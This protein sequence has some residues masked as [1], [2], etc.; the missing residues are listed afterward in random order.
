MS[1]HCRALFSLTLCLFAFGM[2]AQDY[3]NWVRQAPRLLDS[4]FYSSEAR[5]VVD[6][7]LASQLPTGAWPKNV[8]FFQEREQNPGDVMLGTIDNNATSTEIHFLYRYANVLESHLDEAVNICG[9]TDSVHIAVRKA[10]QAGL[11]GILYLLKMQYAN[12]GFPQYYPRKDLYHAR[13]T[14]NDNAMVNV[15]NLL[16]KVARKETPY[17]TVP[18]SVAALCDAAFSRGIDCILRT[19]IVRDGQPTVWCQQ[20]D[21]VTLLPAAARAYELPSFVSAE[22]VGVVEL[23]MSLE[24][25]SDSVC[26]AVEGAM[27]WFEKHAIAGNPRQW[28]RFYDLVECLPFFCGRDGIPHRDLQAIEPERRYGYAWFVTQ[29]ERLFPLYKKWRLRERL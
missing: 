25:P 3:T 24:H 22:S 28:A 26:R 13:I 8:N 20:H 9:T 6:N 16:R 11:D 7:V 2:Q 12:G 5:G 10:R 14:F 1:T 21:E 27:C 18:D 15:L 19:Q 23:L 4:F 17:S 29:P